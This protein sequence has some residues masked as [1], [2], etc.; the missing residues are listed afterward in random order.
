MKCEFPDDCYQLKCYQKN[1]PTVRRISKMSIISAVHVTLSR[2]DIE[3]NF[4][5]SVFCVIEDQK[6]LMCLNKQVQHFKLE[7]PRLMDTK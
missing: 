7:I 4:R 1:L 5:L 2:I 3:L 6:A